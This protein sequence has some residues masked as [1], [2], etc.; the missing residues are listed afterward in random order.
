MDISTPNFAVELGATI[1]FKIKSTSPGVSSQRFER[2]DCG[3]MRPSNPSHTT[4]IAQY[5]KH[6]SRFI[7]PTHGIPKDFRS[8]VSYIGNWSFV[9]NGI[10]YEDKSLKVVCLMSYKNGSMTSHIKSP[11]YEVKEIYGKFK[12]SLV[13]FVYVLSHTAH[14]LNVNEPLYSHY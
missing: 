1:L 7:A 8:R 5:A 4:I 3:I 14:F 10:R 12:N 9:I 13:S 6:S 2:L 11:V